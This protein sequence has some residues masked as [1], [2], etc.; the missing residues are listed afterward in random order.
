MTAESCPPRIRRFLHVFMILP[1]FLPGHFMAIAWIQAFGRAGWITA[2][3]SGNGNLDAADRLA[4][5]VTSAS[6]DMPL[7]PALLYTSA[8]CA[9]VM[10][11]K[12]YPVALIALAAGRLS[13]ARTCIESAG[14]IMNNGRLWS[15]VLKTWLRPWLLIGWLI[16]M[17]RALALSVPYVCISL[18]FASLLGRLIRRVKSPVFPSTPCNLPRLPTGLKGVALTISGLVILF[19]MALPF[20]TLIRMAGSSSSSYRSIWDSSWIQF[21]TS[22]GWAGLASILAAVL[23]VLMS[24]PM[25]HQPRRTGVKSMSQRPAL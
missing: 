7:L 24:L 3:F 8:G 19:A 9:V 25:F 15:L 2:M 17:V 20:G 12:F 5:F 22:I 6:P 1:L 13:L 10:A 14:L 23:A 16:V 11:S 4:G 21:L 18:A